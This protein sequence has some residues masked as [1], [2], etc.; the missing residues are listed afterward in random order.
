MLILQ[1]L[2]SILDEFRLEMG[3]YASGA[4]SL[5]QTLGPDKL[6]IVEMIVN[7][8]RPEAH[9]RIQ[10]FFDEHGKSAESYE[11][12]WK[13]IVPESVFNVL[14]PKTIKLQQ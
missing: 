2:T 13:Q 14:N 10:R 3:M 8:H 9:A 6:V 1:E 12:S 7:F 11:L 4:E 5:V